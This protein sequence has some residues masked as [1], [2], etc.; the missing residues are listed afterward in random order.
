MYFPV[1]EYEGKINCPY[2]VL[3][4]FYSLVNP[5]LPLLFNFMSLY[6]IILVNE[7]EMD[8]IEY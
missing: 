4:I 2:N 8:K 6:F 1:I 5:K 3:L 7:F